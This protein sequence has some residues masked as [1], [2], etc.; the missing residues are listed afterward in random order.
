LG[1]LAALAAWLLPWSSPAPPQ[2][3]AAIRATLPLGPGQR[4]SITETPSFAISRDGTKL[5]YVVVTADGGTELYL[6]E[7][8]S[9][10][11][12]R[13]SDSSGASYPQ[14]APDGHSIAFFVADGL[15]RV[16][17]S[18]GAPVMVAPPG[19]FPG[20]RGLAWGAD[21]FFTVSTYQ[22][23]LTRVADTGGTPAML[24]TP[25]Y[26]TREKS[27]RWPFVMPGSRALLMTVS[28][29]D[30]N[31][32]DDARTEVLRLDSAARTKVLDG[33]SFARYIP[34]GHVLFAR[35]GAL[36]AVPFRL[37]TL[38]VNGLP[39]KVVAPLRTEPA[40][41]HAHFDV[42]DTGTLVYIAS[43]ARGDNRTL[44]WVDAS[45]N[46][47]PAV[48]SKRP[49]YEARISPDGSRVA[50]V[51]EGATSEIWIHDLGDD[52]SMRLTNGW[53]NVN[54]VW[55]PDG[56]RIVFASTRSRRHTHSLFWQAS[57]GTG[58]AEPLLSGDMQQSPVKV[59]SDGT[60]LLFLQRTGSDRWQMHT[61]S[62]VDRSSAPLPETPPIVGQQPALSPD[63]RWV[64]YFS[65]RSGRNEVYVQAFPHGGRQWQVSVGG[66]RAPV[67]A[68]DGKELFYR[69]GDEVMAVSV[70]TA[71][72]VRAGTPRALFNT[73]LIGPVDVGR[74]GRLLMIEPEKEDVVS[75]LAV[76]ANWFDQLTRVMAAPR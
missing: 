36:F 48:I 25:D 41:G 20:A 26:D 38:E 76:V 33:G 17:L 22:T 62:L 55:T 9:S 69:R 68:R 64:A 13:V 37:P 21:G 31:T 4:L 56:E 50:T 74:D 11:S 42:S 46:S 61:L 39:V 19:T 45:G 16:P 65:D 14:F 23:G 49:F 24:T 34:T 44:R 32:F 6:R 35:A 5:A 18:G 58:E 59:S 60:S 40:F 72:A 67:W 8:D 1:L 2:V 7:L 47:A 15:R 75:E 27:H 3:A 63:G 71:V 43:G 70:D 53:D 66:G 73:G 54:P 30:A 57:D 52:K 29:A 28:T 10:A 12:T 51:V